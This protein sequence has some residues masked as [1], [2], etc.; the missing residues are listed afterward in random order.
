MN[1]VEQFEATFR[2]FVI[3]KHAV[4]VCNGTAAIQTGLEVLTLRPGMVVVT[5]PFTFPSPVNA[6]LRCGA[7]PYFVDIDP[8]TYCLD[9]RLVPEALENLKSLRKRVWGVLAVHLFGNMADVRTLQDICYEHKLHLLEDASQAL[10]AK[11]EEQHAGT[12][13]HIGTYSFF[14]TKN[15][16]TF[17]GGMLVTDF[18]ETAERARRIRNHG[19][20]E[21][22]DM[23][24]LGDNRK[25]PWICAFIG[26]TMLRLHKK[27]ILAELG[28]YGPQDHPDI[29]G[30]LVT[31]HPYYRKR[32]LKAH[33]PVAE[34]AAANVRK[35]GP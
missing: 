14:A 29:Y 31:D 34:A 9:S 2:D 12:F 32:G 30:R 6:I 11:D 10:G 8:D 4:A 33:C 25:M 22:G 20:D 26:D 13:G 7:T 35:Q 24:L 23:V 27:A 19:L 16:W 15:L 28:T 17:E 3:S 5:S 1:P 21:H 18:T